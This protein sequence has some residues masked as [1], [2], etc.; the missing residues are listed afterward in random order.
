MS[1]SPGEGEGVPGLERLRNIVTQRT[2]GSVWRAFLVA[3]VAI[4]EPSRR[5]AMT[6]QRIFLTR[7]SSR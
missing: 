5:R 2:N 1:D 4:R 7:Q 3:Q 6:T